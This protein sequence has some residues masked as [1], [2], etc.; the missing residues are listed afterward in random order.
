MINVNKCSSYFMCFSTSKNIRHKFLWNQRNIL[1]YYHGNIDN[2]RC[3][4][5]FELKN[6]SEKT[7]FRFLS[8]SAK[9]AVPLY[10]HYVKSREIGKKR[11]V[12]YQRE[13]IRLGFP[14]MSKDL[15]KKWASA[16]KCA[17][18]GIQ[19]CLFLLINMCLCV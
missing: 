18:K 15:D 10:V 1:D 2:W 17:T 14:E 16:S 5:F 3:L 4:V 9:N 12:Y 8:M 7:N 13:M 6:I 19:P 11:C